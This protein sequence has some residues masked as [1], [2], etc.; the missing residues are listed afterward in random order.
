MSYSIPTNPSQD[1]PTAKPIVETFPLNTSGPSLG[2]EIERV[3][4]DN[5]L[6]I[7]TWSPINCR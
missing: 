3:C 7:A 2:A 6:V 4:L 5:E 1:N